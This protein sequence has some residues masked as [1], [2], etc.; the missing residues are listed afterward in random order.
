MMGTYLAIFLNMA[1]TWT[2]MIVDEHRVEPLFRLWRWVVPLLT[3]LLMI[4]A[5]IL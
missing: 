3:V 5:S 1:S 4:A 2:F